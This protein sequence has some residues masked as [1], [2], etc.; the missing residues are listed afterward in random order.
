MRKTGKLRGERIAAWVA[1]F[2]MHA[3]LGWALLRLPVPMPEGRTKDSV[4][5]VVWVMRPRELPK[6]PEHAGVVA[7]VRSKAL[8]RSTS[9]Q[10]PP[11]SPA[12][13]EGHVATAQPLSA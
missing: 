1:V 2:I 10:V 4:L 5:G 9:L 7:S 8:A 11:A 13:P 6:P 12:S 3:L